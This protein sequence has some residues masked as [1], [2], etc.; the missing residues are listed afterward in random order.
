VN[1][2]H[3]KF[4]EEN[5]FLCTECDKPFEHKPTLLTHIRV[6]HFNYQPYQCKMCNKKFDLTSKLSSHMDS[7]HNIKELCFQCEICSETFPNNGRLY[8]H[9]LKIHNLGPTHVCNFCGKSFKIKTSLTQH[10]KHQHEKSENHICDQ[11]GKSYFS[12]QAMKQHRVIVHESNEPMKCEFEGCDYFYINKTQLRTHMK[13]HG[14]RRKDHKC[15]F[16]P[17]MFP[18]PKEKKRHENTTHLNIRE[19]KCEK[20]DFTT[21]RPGHLK[22]HKESIHEGIMYDCDHPGCVKS[23][24]LKRN[25]DAHRWTSH[26]IPKPIRNYKKD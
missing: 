19:L 13:K 6:D 14:P 21:N 11:C 12:E 15:K 1:T 25:L 24:N 4:S 20:C 23:Y 9:K 26:K 16:C 18:T 7:V 22:N 8:A 17:K 5:S 3:P 10:I 2:N